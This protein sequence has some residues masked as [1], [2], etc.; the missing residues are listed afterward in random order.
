MPFKHHAA[1]AEMPDPRRTQGQR[2]SISHLLLF[3][4]LATF[5]GATSYW[6]IIAFIALQSERLNTVFGACSR[7]TPAAGTLR[8]LFLA[9]GRD[10]FE[11]AF[12]RQAPNRMLELGRPI[13][14]R[15]A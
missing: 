8:H 12:R 7:C 13:S 14:A 9:P 15:T 4:V 11:A 6:E 1:L 3:S 5:A 2:Y 10:D